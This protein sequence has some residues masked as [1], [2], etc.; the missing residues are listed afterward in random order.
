M[1]VTL[2]IVSG[3]TPGRRFDV[4]DGLVARFGRTEW[5]D[6]SLPD[7][8]MAD[9]HFVLDCRGLN[10]RLQSVVASRPVLV[11]GEPAAEATLHTGDS[12]QAGQTTFQVFVEG[13]TERPATA[14]ETPAEPPPPQHRVPEQSAY[15]RLDK[16]DQQLA[17]PEMSP[18]DYTAT[19]V[20]KDRLL[21]AIKWQA[22]VL[23]KRSA[24]WWGCGAVERLC[25]ELE[26]L[27]K[28]AWEAARTWAQEPTEPHRRAAESAAEKAG[29]EGPGGLL[30]AA[31]FWSGNNLAPENSPAPVPPDDRLTAT[32]VSGALTV[33]CFLHP[34]ESAARQ[35][36]CLTWAREVAAKPFASGS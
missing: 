15:L 8:D 7:P 23:P 1:R 32:G 21:P 9:V 33:A 2:Q 29:Y 6:F 19:L 14:E 28:E 22:F 36:D 30:A 13:E 5:A 4:R 34:A 25:G 20:A 27:Q 12:L 16:A 26:P 11:N 10:C 18:D 17:T 31:A 35:R 24:V 3:A